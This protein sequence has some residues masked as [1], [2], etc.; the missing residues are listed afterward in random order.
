MTFIL[1]FVAGIA[2]TGAVASLFAFGPEKLRSG[3]IAV[4][5]FVI[6]NSIPFGVT[7]RLELQTS[8]GRIKLLTVGHG[9]EDLFIIRIDDRHEMLVRDTEARYRFSLWHLVPTG[10]VLMLTRLATEAGKLEYGASASYRGSLLKIDPNVSIFTLNKESLNERLE[11][12][13]RRSK[14]PMRASA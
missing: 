2:A 13:G 1:G 7:R 3:G 12:W 6:R 11:S 14:P 8:P 5:G 4:L 9:H 10:L